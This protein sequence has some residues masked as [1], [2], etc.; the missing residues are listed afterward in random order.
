MVCSVLLFEIVLF[1]EKNK[2]FYKT[3][4]NNKTRGHRVAV[5]VQERMN[6]YVLL[7]LYSVHMNTP[8]SC[9]PVSQKKMHRQVGPISRSIPSAI[10]LQSCTCPCNRLLSHEAAAAP[11]PRPVRQRWWRP[12]HQQR[13]FLNGRSVGARHNIH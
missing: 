7:T 5:P 12:L 9:D 13:G 8:V 10:P 4:E 1:C 2:Y 11:I 3:S 6:G